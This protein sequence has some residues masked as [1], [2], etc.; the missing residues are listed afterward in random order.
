[1]N[2]LSAGGGLSCLIGRFIKNKLKNPAPEFNVGE[3]M[4]QSAVVAI[5]A[6][7]I[8]NGLLS[9]AVPSWPAAVN[10]IVSGVVAFIAGW[11]TMSM[12]KK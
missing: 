9:W 8:V 5:A 7:F 10:W 4:S 2:L 1:M 3:T 12:G 6:A 11:A